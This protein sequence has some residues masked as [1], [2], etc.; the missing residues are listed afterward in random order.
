MANTGK[1][2]TRYGTNPADVAHYAKRSERATTIAQEVTSGLRPKRSLNG[3]ASFQ[4]RGLQ[5][6]HH[7]N[8]C[9]RG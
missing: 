2:G 7:A 3:I 8:V 5:R 4:L 1:T 6:Q 9:A